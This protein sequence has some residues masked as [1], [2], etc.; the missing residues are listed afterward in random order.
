MG[1]EHN[2]CA[3][4]QQRLMAAAVASDALLVARVPQELS[5]VRLSRHAAGTVRIART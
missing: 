4:R 2:D 1:L 3:V 5:A